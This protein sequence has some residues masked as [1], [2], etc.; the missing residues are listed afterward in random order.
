MPARQDPMGER[1]CDREARAEN[2]TICAAGPRSCAERSFEED[3]PQPTVRSSSVRRSLAVAV[4]MVVAA[5]GGLAADKSTTGGRLTRSAMA[6]IG[7]SA[8]AT[9]AGGG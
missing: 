8:S 3:L 5:V 4:A 1:A 7:G 6:G 2:F 9:A